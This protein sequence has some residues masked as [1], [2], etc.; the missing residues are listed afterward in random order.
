MLDGMKDFNGLEV[1]RGV[2]ATAIDI[3]E[4]LVHDPNAHAVTLTVKHLSEEELAESSRKFTVPQ[5]GD[6][7]YQ[8]ADEPHR[9]R[10]VSGKEGTTETIRAKFVI[11]SDGGQSWTRQALGFDF[12]GDDKGNE[13]AGG[14]LDCMATTNFR[15]FT[16][17]PGAL[18]KLTYPKADCGGHATIIK[19][20]R[21][22]G[23]IPRENGLTRIVTTLTSRAEAT[24]EAIAKTFKELVAP[25]EFNV[26]QVDWCGVF[27]SRRRVA[28][29]ASKY[30]RVFLTGDALH[31]HSPTA[32]VGMN[33]S[34]QDGKDF[35][36][37]R[38]KTLLTMLAYNLGWKVAHVAKG[39]SPIAV[40][41]TYDEER[42]FT[43]D[44]LIA[45]DKILTAVANMRDWSIEG[46]SKIITENLPFSSTAGIEYENGLLIAKEGGSIASKPHLASGIT[47]GARMPSQMVAKHTSGVPVEFGNLIPSDGRYTIVIFAGN[48]S[49]P[50]Q[51]SRV[52]HVSQVLELP[53]AFSQRLKQHAIDP[54]DVF[55]TLVL[56]T[57]SRDEVEITDLPSS[58][59]LGSNPLGQVYVDNDQVRIWTLNE[60]Y[61][62]YGIDRERGCLVLVRPDRHVMYIGDLEDVD[63]LEK[64][65]SLALV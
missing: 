45:F 63:K 21:V 18:P 24:P 58:L 10:K 20:G 6:F 54:Q 59:F 26:T 41:K 33:F 16:L 48:L 51:L 11:G 47:V 17:F 19:E 15:K 61:K 25:Y 52:K 46:S 29:S 55:Q 7:N 44:K 12:L 27:G 14:I 4:S 2:V 31:I 57:G 13:I 42:G 23:Y 22:A 35:S 40:L 8:P 38:H 50:E 34:L 56:H 53:E 49:K 64:L 30:S 39:I 5:P 32:G 65:V 62:G 36:P 1:E 28:S 60:A 3:N 9:V 43:T 37:R